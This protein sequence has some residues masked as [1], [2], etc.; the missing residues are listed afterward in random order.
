M[1]SLREAAPVH[2]TEDDIKQ[3][4]KKFCDMFE[5]C[6]ECPVGSTGT[7]GCILYFLATTQCR[8]IQ[9]LSEA[10]KYCRHTEVLKSESG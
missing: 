3:F 6:S 7:D 1:E 5:H 4:A 2:I 10:I 8:P 9:D